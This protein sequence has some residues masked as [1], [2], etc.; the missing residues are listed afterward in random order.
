VV[1]RFQQM[2]F[3]HAVLVSRAFSACSSLLFHRV[4]SEGSQAKRARERAR[5]PPPHHTAAITIHN[6]LLAR[7][8]AAECATLSRSWQHGEHIIEAKGA[9]AQDRQDRVI[10]FGAHTEHKSSQAC[11]E[12][13]RASPC[14]RKCSLHCP[15]ASCTPGRRRERR[16]LGKRREQPPGA[17]RK[18][19]QV[20]GDHV[21]RRGRVGRALSCHW[22]TRV[23]YVGSALASV[24]LFCH[25]DSRFL[26][27]LL[28]CDRGA[29]VSL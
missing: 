18:T 5:A 21:R 24:C 11:R 15:A 29:C 19:S 28:L 14:C 7:Q 25:V 1:G 27:L 9:R 16:E 3:L 4:H 13:P 8:K 2:E 6:G 22:H 10:H 12:T 23:W 26:T 17:C 20:A